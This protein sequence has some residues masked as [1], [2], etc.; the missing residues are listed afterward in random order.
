[1]RMPSP[2]HSSASSC[3]RKGCW[4]LCTGTMIAM[5]KGYITPCCLSRCN[6][7]LILSVYFSYLHI[8]CKEDKPLAV[9]CFLIKADSR[10]KPIKKLLLL[11]RPLRYRDSLIKPRPN[12]EGKDISGAL[13]FCQFFQC[14]TDIF[15]RIILSCRMIQIA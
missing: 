1:M 9:F 7:S 8:F 10:D 4:G 15:H 2:S 5:M 14:R 3:I 12:C 6:E 13:N 11:C